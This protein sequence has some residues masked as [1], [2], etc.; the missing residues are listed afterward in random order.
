MRYLCLVLTVALCV[1]LPS[2]SVSAQETKSSI[3]AE[4]YNLISEY[5]EQL[6]QSINY[7]S[8]LDS[9]PEKTVSIIVSEKMNDYRSDLFKLQSHPDVSTRLL[10]NEIEA[11][12]SRAEAIGRIAWIYHYNVSSISS[13]EA[14]ARIDALY[15]SFSDEISAQTNAAVIDAQANVI[16]ND[17]NKAIYIEKARVLAR[18][19]DSIDSAA[20]IAGAISKLETTS[21][22]DIFGENF[23]AIFTELT[24]KLSLQRTRDDLTAELRSVFSLICSGESFNSNEA[25]TLFVYNVKNAET[26]PQMN[27]ALTDAISNLTKTK[28]KG[29]YS[30]IYIQTLNERVADTAN[31]SSAAG[32]CTSILSIFENYS[33]DYKRSLTKDDIA[34]MLLENGGSEHEPLQNAEQIFN[35]TGGIIDNCLTADELLCEATRAKYVRLLFDE[36][37]SAS[38]K[39]AIFLGSYDASSFSARLEQI[40]SA[41]LKKLWEEEASAEFEAKC[42]ELLQRERAD[43]SELLNEAKAERFLLDNKT[44]LQKPKES[45]TLADEY[46]LRSAISEYISLDDT[47][48]DILKSQIDGIAEKY[49]ILICQ[50][51]RSLL[52]DDDL[53]LDLCEIIC[54]EAKSQSNTNIAV[55]Y[56]NC[57]R[58]FNKAEILRGVIQYFR[59]ISST[60][61]YQE[62]S[63]AEKQE[64]DSTC[65]KA[66]DLLQ[67]S[68]PNDMLDYEETLSGILQSSKLS[69]DRTNE[70]AR[71]RIAA[72]GSKSAAVQ[73]L[74][75][76]AGAKIKAS[77]NKSDMITLADKMIFK[78]NR[79]LTKDAI[80]KQGD[81]LTLLISKMS[82]LSEAERSSFANAVKS[83]QSS[84]INDAGVAENIT[85]LSF[86]WSIFQENTA[87][88]NAEASATDLERASKSYVD[89]FEKDVSNLKSK[90]DAMAHLESK[91]RDEFSNS[92]QAI[93]NQLK[94]DIA[95]CISSSE[96]AAKYTNALEK[97]YSLEVKA[98]A[99][100][101]ENYKI[102]IKERLESFKSSKN[103]YSV[104]NYNKIEQEIAKSMQELPACQTMS[105]CNALLDKT[106]STIKSIFTL[107]DD[108]KSSARSKLDT[109]IQV[110]RANASQY[111]QEN[112]L[113]IEELYN[114][115]IKKISSFTSISDIPALNK[116]LTDSLTA[117]ASVNKNTLFTSSEAE[118]MISPSAKYPLGYDLY[119]G[120]WGCVY[121]NDG[122]LSG[123]TFTASKIDVN[124][125][126]SIQALIRKAARSNT[127]ATN[128][129]ISQSTLKELKKCVVTLGIDLS[130]SSI[131]ETSGYYN[132]KLLLP[133]TLTN[134][135][136]IGIAFVD[137]DNNVEFY[138]VEQDGALLSFDLSHFSHYY[139]VTEGT[140][141]LS[142]LIAFLTVLLAI[143][144]LTLCAVLTLHVYRKRK[145]RNMFSSVF[146]IAPIFPIGALRVIPNNGAGICVM[147]T[148]AVVALGCGIAFLTKIE[149]ESLKLLREKS[150]GKNVELST[151]I[152]R[153]TKSKEEKNAVL[154]QKIPVL[155]GTNA[156][157]L[158]SSEEDL[159]FSSEISSEI[160]DVTEDATDSEHRPLPR[161]AEINLDVIADLFDAGALVTPEALKQKRLISKRTEHVKIL[162][163]GT[164]T[165]PLVIE[166]HDF[167][168]AAEEMLK[169]IGGEAIRIK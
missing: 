20:L 82:F 13:T 23:S 134:E 161:K 24:E 112:M 80:T 38:Q 109:A 17:L 125:R 121:K 76:E 100:N 165:K 79:E 64:L 27:S 157:F 115:S 133:D 77:N 68:N 122:L 97:L 62:Y 78:I 26:I 75:A 11:A 158:P 142:G 67:K 30:S 63:N 163:R 53:Y 92:S 66:S 42:I 145:E 123:A 2:L 81:E 5:S 39:L 118:A 84:A 111:S 143:E 126:A 6:N 1:L 152:E 89:L 44:I 93:L 94:A 73:A 128:G 51:I 164:L 9:S 168:H 141:N 135:R 146:A 104:E 116:H 18:A 16:C 131:A 7:Y 105:E 21:S 87:A 151:D 72:R 71:V 37:I 150:K 156:D 154:E 31:R 132:V 46:A 110:C 74:V 162:A 159:D 47:V 22:S 124:N 19:N 36:R 103:N 52:P 98:S 153:S 12:Y 129:A 29:N 120:I 59:Q 139:I 4:N 48:K 169:A 65:Q 86:V 114:E 54:T 57:D 33:I 160:A 35:A 55:F 88:L 3:I 101:V 117:I 102:V 69:M 140:T 41:A 95:Q 127:L 49:N 96:V 155:C 137:K 50:K 8:E 25:T 107:L 130:L 167:S 28:I 106:V 40:C 138:H 91:S 85:V 99:E 58:I 60:P 113:K 45:I 70:C 83:A 147:L 43:C 148:V 32:V 14:I 90:L 61:I 56:N 15:S 10:K 149:L 119:S 144:I 136:I 34:L 108:A 166:A